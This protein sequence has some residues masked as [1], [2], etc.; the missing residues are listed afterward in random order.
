MGLGRGGI[1]KWISVQHA[2]SHQGSIAPCQ[3][4]STRRSFPPANKSCPVRH[5]SGKRLV[6]LQIMQ[7]RNHRCLGKGPLET[8][9]DDSP[10]PK[11]AYAV[12]WIAVDASG[13]QNILRDRTARGSVGMKA[14]NSCFASTTRVFRPH[15]DASN[16]GS[17]H[18][19]I[20]QR[21]CLPVQKWS[22]TPASM[23]PHTHSSLVLC[24]SAA[25][26]FFS[27]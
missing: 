10:I 4:N 2:E 12:L 19:I 20:P 6:E 16:Q 18:V 7:G 24:S 9:P 13:L 1:G 15:I 14:E 23:L 25:G 8:V 3:K 17:P 5:S 21:A 22:I 27:K 11:P 26:T